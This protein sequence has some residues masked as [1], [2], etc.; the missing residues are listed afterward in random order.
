MAEQWH[1]SING[2]QRGPLSSE[3]VRQ[4]AARGQLQPT[5]H[6]WKDGMSDWVAASSVRG[7][8]PQQPPPSPRRPGP[9]PLNPFPF[10]TQAGAAHVTATR[11]G[12]VSFGEA[13]SRGFAK[14]FDFNGRATRAEFWWF[15]LLLMIIWLPLCFFAISF[16]FQGQAIQFLGYAFWA[17]VLSGVGARRLHDTNHSGW[18]QL[19]MFTGIGAIAL[20]IWWCQKGTPGRNRFG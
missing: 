15:Y 5:D 4:L 14:L 18:W 13:A 1:V 7:L 8:F 11:S 2:T 10:V 17:V 6:I 9:P 16:G 3:Q 12:P 19:L 20:L